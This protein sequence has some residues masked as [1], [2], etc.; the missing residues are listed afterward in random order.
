MPNRPE[1]RIHDEPR[2]YYQPS[3]DMVHMLN[4]E[5]CVSDERY[6]GTLFQELVHSTGHKSRLNREAEMNGWHS[7]G[8]KEYSREELV[9]EMGAGFLCADCGI[10]Q[11]IEEDAAAYIASWLTRLENDRTLVIAAAGKAAKAFDY[12]MGLAKPKTGESK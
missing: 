1:I 4:R 12:I 9:A 5:R 2:A 10:F 11:E 7:F 8:S 6:H 3:T